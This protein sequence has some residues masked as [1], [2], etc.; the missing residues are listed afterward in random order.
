MKPSEKPGTG[1]KAATAR[2]IKWDD[3]SIKRS[4]ANT[5]NVAATREEFTLIF[6]NNQSF[7]QA[8]KELKI[9]LT[10]RMVLSPYAAKRFL[11]LLE[12]A[13]K[14]YEQ[15]FGS[16]SDLETTGSSPSGTN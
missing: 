14:S 10:D 13:V 2:T 15:K 3:S 1:T 9:E 5:C 12:S 7:D 4:Y 11:V 16:L 6:G 8:Q